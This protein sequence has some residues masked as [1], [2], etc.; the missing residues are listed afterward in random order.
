MLRGIAGVLAGGLVVL[1]VALFVVAF[2][3]GRDGV[4]GP[5]TGTLTA[6]V[7]AAVVAV[8]GQ[9]VADR[10]GDRA[11]AVAALGVVGIAVLVLG[12]GWFA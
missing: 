11:G 1:A 7:G 6:H 8:A 12:L 3:A 10:R 9:L 5:G 2:V 4:P